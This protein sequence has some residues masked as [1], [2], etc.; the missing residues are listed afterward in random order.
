MADIDAELTAAGG[1][2]EIDLVDIRGVMT[3]VWRHAPTS[4]AEMLGRSRSHG[5]GPFLVYE[6]ETLSFEDHFRAAAQVAHGLRS[7]FGVAKGDRVAIV[8]R[9]YPEWSVGFWGAAAAGA[10]V[11]AVNAWWTPDEVRYAL[12]DS[13][14][15]VVLADA[16]RAAMVGAGPAE[17]VV[18][19]PG[20]AVPIGWSDVFGVPDSGIDLPDV[21]FAPEDPATIFYTSGTSG[22]PKGVVGTHRNI[23][24]N[25][26]TSR[27]V[28]ERTAVRDGSPSPASSVYLLSVPLF[29]ATGC[30]SL[31]VGH[32]HNGATMVMMHRWDPGRALELIERHR[33][34][35]FGGVPAMALQVLDHPDLQTRDTSSV[36]AVRFGGAP[37]PAGLPGRIAAAFPGAQA[38]NGYG[39]TETSA[40]STMNAGRDYLSRPDSVGVPPPVVEVRVVDD[41]GRD[42]PVGE[43]GELW[44]KGPHVVPGYWRR[45]EATASTFTAGW[46]HTG[47]L[48]RLDGDG[49]LYVVDRAKDM[50]IRGGENIYCIE[51]ESVVHAHPAVAEAAVIGVAHPTL[52][53]E[54][55]AVVRLRPG[56]PLSP[57]ELEEW[58][59]PRLAAYKR[60]ARI[61]L[62][63][64]ELPRNPAGKVLKA[65]LRR[66]LLAP[67]SS[68]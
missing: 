60:P 11:V 10:V 16:E 36:T 4:L 30:H 66:Q 32:L 6:D 62:V 7:R 33:V 56:H 9:N 37:A 46:V 53:E 38:M 1:P 34:T 54:V 41:D 59:R 51:V 39:M 63:D 14:A 58:L 3:R 57:G 18:A 19:R 48:A 25:P 35:S 52:G 50:V 65:E 2:F 21:T 49:Y 64:T 12:D 22:R 67:P 5:G 45:P 27:F 28:R 68:S 42:R 20:G 43:V 61:W 13:G 47:D 24:T 40:L 23:C 17:V 15:R 26:I 29:H 44:I 31:L 8:M 55:G